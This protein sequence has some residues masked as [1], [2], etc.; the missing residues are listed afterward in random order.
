VLT[1]SE[2]T[3]FFVAVG[4][5][6]TFRSLDSPFQA[7]LDVGLL[8][9]GALCSSKVPLVRIQRSFTHLYCLRISSLVNCHV[10]QLILSVLH[11]RVKKTIPIYNHA[12]ALQVTPSLGP[13]IV[14]LCY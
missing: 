10:I 7:L 2:N 11:V 14:I 5:E 3:Q 6:F 1:E 4:F 13:V 9:S 12:L 8:F